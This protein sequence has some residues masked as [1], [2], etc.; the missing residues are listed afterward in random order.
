M[1]LLLIIKCQVI[2]SAGSLIGDA[3]RIIEEARKPEFPEKTPRSRVENQQTQPT[4]NV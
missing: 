4:C 2:P 3:V 1:I